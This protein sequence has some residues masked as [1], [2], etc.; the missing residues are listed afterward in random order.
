MK[1]VLISALIIILALPFASLALDIGDAAPD[2]TLL[3]VRTNE[4]VSLSSFR[5]QVVVLQ[6][7]KCQ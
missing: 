5:G 1:T 4:P 6:F 2:F 7:M 3:E